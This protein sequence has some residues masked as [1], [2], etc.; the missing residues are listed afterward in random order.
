MAETATYWICRCGTAVDKTEMR[1]TSCQRRRNP[2][3]LILALCVGGI[4]GLSTLAQ[5]NTP[6]KQNSPNDLHAQQANFLQQLSNWSDK[7][8][9]QPNEIAAADFT[10][11]RD[12]DLFQKFA[13][14]Q[15]LSNW[16]GTISGIASMTG[17]GG[18]SVD[19]GGAHLIAG[20][21]YRMHLDTL[22][23]PED[24]L[25]KTLLTLSTG[26][27]VI[28]SGE[29]PSNPSSSIAT[30]DYKRTHSPDFLFKFSQ[31]TKVK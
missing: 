14:G 26:D 1:C 12:A 9:G 15:T 5:P 10:L 23:K 11:R 6:R 13:N 7:I 17:G 2:G 22:I 31:L 21:H 16:S 4:V 29:F 27:R 8:T 24:R 3:W 19:I 20:V 28:F 25:F 30:V 18:L